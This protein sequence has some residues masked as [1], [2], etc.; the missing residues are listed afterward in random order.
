MLRW[1]TGTLS[2]VRWNAAASGYRRRARQRPGDPDRR[3]AVDSAGCNHAAGNPRPPSTGSRSSRHGAR[4]DHA[5]PPSCVHDVSADYVLYAGSLLEHAPSGEL[6]AEPLHPYTLGL[7]LSEPSVD[8]RYEELSAMPGSVPP[9]DDVADRCPFEPRCTW[10][11]P[12]CAIGQPP[13]RVVAPLRTSACVRIDLIR[14]ACPREGRSSGANPYTDNGHGRA[15]DTSRRG[16]DEDLPR[17][18]C[19]TRCKRSSR[20]V[21]GRRRGRELGLV[22]E[23]GSGQDDACALCRRAGEAN[24][25]PN[26][27]ERR[28]HHRFR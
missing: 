17:A 22:G 5:R 23:S 8:R 13:L 16:A 15:A 24:V 20:G 19:A 11:A 6:E 12:E 14:P 2:A 26:R 25:R 27:G 4:V 7:L 28:R 9:A 10:A 1:P 21:A 3:R 18:R